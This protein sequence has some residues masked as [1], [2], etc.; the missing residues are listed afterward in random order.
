LKRLALLLALAAALATA[1]ALAVAAAAAPPPVDAEAYFVQNAGTGE[2]LAADDERERLPM[3]SITKLMTAIVALERASLDDVATVSRRTASI[4][5]STINLRPGERVTLRDLIRAALIQSANDAANAIAAY[6]GR[7]SVERFVELMNARARQLGLTDTHFAN[8][9]GLDAPGHVSS[10]RDVTKL[11]R[12]AMNKPFIRETVG[13]Q[14]ATAAGRTLHTWNDLLSRFPNLIGVKTGHTN[15]AGWSQVAAARGGGVTVYAT[16]LGGESREGRN[17][18]LAELLAWG[19]SRYRTVW[20]VDGGRTYATART[21]YGRE[22][23]RL[24]AAKPALRVIHVERPLVERV[25]APVEVEL[26]VRK[27][28]RLG[29]VQVLDRGV[30]I[31]RSALVAANAVGKPGTVGRVRFYAGRTLDHL[32]GLFP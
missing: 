21:G 1:L 6:V 31:A 17:A 2:V 20:A 32:G 13:L 14:T 9:D 23:V 27:G 5:E 12:V 29:E 18:D 7:G 26:P 19:L 24:V 4:G 16:V 28:Q 11:A 8:P 22:R 25:V 15:G 10:A 3:A 30:V